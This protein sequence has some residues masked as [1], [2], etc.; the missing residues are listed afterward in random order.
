MTAALEQ[1]L[2]ALREQSD[3]DA[4]LAQLGMAIEVVDHEFNAAI[5]QIRTGLQEFRA[6]AKSNRSLNPLYEKIRISFE[7]L[8]GYLMLFTPFSR[9]LRRQK[10]EISGAQIAKFIKDLFG[11]R[12]SRHKIGFDV[13]SAFNRVV[14]LG[15]P[16]TFYPVFVNLIDNAVFWLSDRPTPRM[17]ELDAVD[18]ALL[19]RDNGPGISVRDTES[20]F[21]AG[22]SR[23]PG[24]R[25]L[26]L[27]ISKEALIK[28]GYNLKIMTT[29]Q[30]ET[31]FSIQKTNDS[32]PED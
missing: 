20:V 16:S 1:E 30:R 2:V 29:G 4:E 7:H 6:W 27:H 19:V 13:T 26:G 24:G 25:G 22:F 23:K 8:D 14:T 9:R 15:Y 21:R 5:I 11:E 10:V 17:I 28:I 31:A 3:N 32:Q 12:F 18:G